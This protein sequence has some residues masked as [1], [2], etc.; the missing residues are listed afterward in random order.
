MFKHF[1]ATSYNFCMAKLRTLNVQT[2][3]H[4]VSLMKYISN[5]LHSNGS[6]IFIIAVKEMSIIQQHIYDSCNACFQAINV[7]VST[8]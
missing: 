8:T 5:I 2:W 3:V 6:Y 4:T 7:V 1:M